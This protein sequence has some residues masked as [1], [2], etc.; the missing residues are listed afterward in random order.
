MK[1]FWNHHLVEWLTTRNSKIGTKSSIWLCESMS[2]RA[3]LWG[4]WLRETMAGVNTR[5]I[6]RKPRHATAKL[7]G[8]R[9]YGE[10]R[11]IVHSVHIK[12]LLHSASFTE[13]S[14]VRLTNL[15]GGWSS[16]IAARLAKKE[17][18]SNHLPTIHCEGVISL[19]GIIFH[20]SRR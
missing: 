6:L 11:S 8:L 10:K 1:Y 9:H 19:P 4:A 20:C 15:D 7:L 12:C 5:E 2:G 17:A 13:S 14:H 16:W 18:K 3:Q